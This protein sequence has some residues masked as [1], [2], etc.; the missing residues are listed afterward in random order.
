MLLMGMKMS[1]TKKPTNPITT[2][3][4]AVRTA[5]LEN[6]EI[7]KPSNKS[8]S[9]EHRFILIQKKWENMRNDWKRW[10]SVRV[11]VAPLRSGLWHRLTSLTLSL[12]NSLS[13]SNTESMASILSPFLLPLNLNWDVN[14]SEWWVKKVEIY[15]TQKINQKISGKKKTDI[16]ID[17]Y[18]ANSMVPGWIL[19]CQFG[20][21]YCPCHIK[22]INF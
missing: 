20:T 1:L 21:L 14:K 10:R 4:I 15:R 19:L 7:P 5:T 3:P 11:R 22:H 9:T 16:G 6:S 12:A 2:K 17:V 18:W 8:R 13:G